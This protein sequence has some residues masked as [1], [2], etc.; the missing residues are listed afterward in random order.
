MSAALKLLAGRQIFFR[1]DLDIEF[2]SGG[3]S[4]RPSSSPD[5]K[6]LVMGT[7]LME[8]PETSA[9][10]E[11]VNKEPRISRALFGTDHVDLPIPE[12]GN[13][14]LSGHI[15]GPLM[16]EYFVRSDY[17]NQ[18]DRTTIVPSAF[19]SVYRQ[20]EQ[21]IFDP[22]TITVSSLVQFRN[23]KTEIETVDLGDGIR[24]RRASDEERKQA[25][26]GSYTGAAAMPGMDVYEM[27]SN[28]AFTS[29][30]RDLDNVP[31]VLLEITGHRGATRA[32]DVEAYAERLLLALRLIN[33]LPVA[34][35]SFWYIDTN[36]F[37]AIV[38]PR[39]VRHET[40]P[41]AKPEDPYVITPEIAS[42]V[43]ELWPKLEL[44]IQDTQLSL[45]VRRLDDSYYRKQPEDQL[46]DLWVALEAL[47]LQDDKAELQFR[48]ALMIARYIGESQDERWEIYEHVRKA[49]GLR[50][51]LVHGGLPKKNINVP[52]LA[53]RAG[54]YLR[55]ALLRCLPTHKVPDSKEILKS[56]LA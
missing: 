43:E 9:V 20:L 30:K 4:S 5:Y 17:I 32:A 10:L 28:P 22:E 46:I 6:H 13:L 55:R 23:L 31:D 45:A 35:H 19:D 42:Q 11:I 24:L 37:P 18:V 34:I 7:E 40:L 15:L 27:F 52:E 12:L 3:Y 21:F 38:L 49:Y 8:L 41:F 29:E 56:L 53:E 1:P 50:S 25:V 48:A 33:D 26:K 36:P 51:K 47:F 14:M 54:N 39:H 2:N 16:V 44:R